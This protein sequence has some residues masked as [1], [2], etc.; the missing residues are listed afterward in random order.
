MSTLIIYRYHDNCHNIIIF[1]GDDNTDT[2]NTNIRRHSST[3]TKEGIAF[4]A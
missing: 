4:S 3:S 1:G 2:K